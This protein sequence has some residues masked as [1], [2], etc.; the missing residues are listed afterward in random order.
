MNREQH[1]SSIDAAPRRIWH[2][3]DWNF[4]TENK[5]ITI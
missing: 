4:G 5:V 1:A 2:Y 3:V